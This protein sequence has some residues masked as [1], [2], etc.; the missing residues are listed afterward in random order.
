MFCIY[1]VKAAGLKTCMDTIKQKFHSH[2]QSKYINYALANLEQL[3]LIHSN[4]LM[5]LLSKPA[6]SNT[7][8][9][10]R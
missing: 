10:S 3:L 6:I 5:S 8:H 2:D 9:D 1:A 4:L 7:A